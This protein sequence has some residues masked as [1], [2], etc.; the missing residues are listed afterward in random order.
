MDLFDIVF[1]L[2]IGPLTFRTPDKNIPVKPGMV[3]RAEIRKTLQTGIVLAETA[4]PPKGEIKKIAEIV[5]DTPVFDGLLLN[6]LKWTS[7]YYIVPAGLALKSMFPMEIFEKIR[8]RRLMGGDREKPG[9]CGNPHIE[10]IPGAVNSVRIVRDS[11]SRKEY[12]T[13]LFNAPTTDYE[14]SFIL[15]AAA[16][17]S[18][19]IVLV[20]ETMNLE[21]ITPSFRKLFGQRLAVIHG[22][23]TKA[24]RRNALFRILSGESDIVIGTRVAVFAPL[25]SVSLIAVLHEHNRS[26]KNMEGLRYN[27]RD[28]AVM[29][30]YLNKSTVLLS[31]VTPS[32]ESFYNTTAG[33]YTL[34]SANAEIR[35]PKIEIINMKTAAR[36]TPYLS[37]RAIEASKLCVRKKERILFLINRKGY[38][39]IQ[40]LECSHVE[41]CP[42]CSIPLVYHRDKKLLKCHY[43]GHTS[44]LKEKCARCGGSKL[45]TIGAGNQRIAADIKKYLDIEPLL[46]D[47][48]ASGKKRLPELPDEETKTEGLIVGTKVVAGNPH[49]K[50]T[51]GLCVFLNPDSSLNF[52]DFRSSELLFQDLFATSEYL[53]A[54]GL[55]IIHTKMPGNHVYKCF[56]KYGYSLFCSEELAKRESLLYPPFSRLALIT[57]SSKTD[58]EKALIECIISAETDTGRTVEVIGPL[59]AAQKGANKWKLLVKSPAKVRLHTYVRLFLKK[60]E[61]LKEVRII[62]DVDPISI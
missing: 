4:N 10:P 17:V 2:N 28:V 34:L 58:I 18:N 40:C 50:G 59:R 53:A 9:Q 27:A 61:N 35:R 25:Q 29:R 1:P 51:L 23:M 42:E 32:I 12:K 3:V 45:E 41:T 16:G 5:F 36:L 62:V 38:S 19:A 20:P 22:K 46:M 55:F 44:G 39:L 54:G 24:Q 8:P 56:K 6:L 26:Y 52:P 48:D 14:L 7:D 30:A 21:F 47:K 11:V 43:C 60:M 31:S 37:K 57:V 49:L 33:K 15:D 13:Y